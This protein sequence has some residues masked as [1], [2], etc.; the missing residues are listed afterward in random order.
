[1]FIFCAS[2]AIDSYDSREMIE[3]P[4]HECLHYFNAPWK[5]VNLFK[6]STGKNDWRMVKLFPENLKA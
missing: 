3:N 1:M 2:A 4:N 5:P 6:T